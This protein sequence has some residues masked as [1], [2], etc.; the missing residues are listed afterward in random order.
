[1]D[2]QTSKQLDQLEIARQAMLLEDAQSV[3]QLQREVARQ[4][5]ATSLGVPLEAEPAVIKIGDTH[6]HNYP[7]QPPSATAPSLIRKLMPL[8]L[9]GA[10]LLAGGIGGAG[11]V[12]MLTKP[13]SAEWP[14]KEFDIFWKFDGTDFKV[15][16]IKPVEGK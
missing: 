1:M 16:K 2:N 14:A 9:T 3:L 15:D 10:G 4:H 8:L 5:Q 11:L 7:T 6:T 12:S 13:A